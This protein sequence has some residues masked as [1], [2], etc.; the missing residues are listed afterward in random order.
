MNCSLTSSNFVKY[1][2]K[3]RSC[4]STQRIVSII[5]E[6]FW[7]V[8]YSICRWSYSLAM[9]MKLSRWVKVLIF[10][11]ALNFPKPLS[12]LVDNWYLLMVLSSTMCS[13]D[14]CKAAFIYEEITRRNLWISTQRS[15]FHLLTYTYTH[16]TCK[17][18]CEFW[19][20]QHTQHNHIIICNIID[21][22]PISFRASVLYRTKWSIPLIDNR[23]M[24]THYV[25]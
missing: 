13:R 2:Y 15:I 20:Q 16:R 18:F 12:S 4:S 5:A 17:T 11:I 1:K 21:S 22:T 14:H 10:L 9:R 24:T 7:R 8:P 25:K 3:S 19:K 23:W 6:H